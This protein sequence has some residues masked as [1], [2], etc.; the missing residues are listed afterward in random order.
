LQDAFDRLIRA[1]YQA[2]LAETELLRLQGN[3]LQ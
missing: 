3:F 2:K 1:R